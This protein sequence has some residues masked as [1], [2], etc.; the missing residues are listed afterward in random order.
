MNVLKPLPAWRFLPDEFIPL[1][2]RY[3]PVLQKSLV[4]WLGLAKQCARGIA[5]AEETHEAIRS[6]KI[7]ADLESVFRNSGLWEQE[8]IYWLDDVAYSKNTGEYREVEIVA[9]IFD[10]VLEKLKRLLWWLFDASK[11]KIVSG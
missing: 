4:H 2:I 3:I 7:I 5:L 9:I 8:L 1:F 6:E 10:L 11:K